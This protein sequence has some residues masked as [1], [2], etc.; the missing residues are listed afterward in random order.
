MIPEK[1]PQEANNIRKSKNKVETL[2]SFMDEV[3]S[4]NGNEGDES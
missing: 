1:N 4:D 2:E 3:I